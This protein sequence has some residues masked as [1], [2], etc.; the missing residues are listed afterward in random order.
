[1]PP[2]ELLDAVGLARETV[3]DPD[4]RIPADRADAMWNANSAHTDAHYISQRPSTRETERAP[5]VLL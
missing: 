2:G 4:A 3:Y 1:M 5:D